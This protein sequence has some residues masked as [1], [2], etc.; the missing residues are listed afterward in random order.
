M[1]HTT[2]E[3]PQHTKSGYSAF[4]FSTNTGAEF[5]LKP[6]LSAGRDIINHLQQSLEYTQNGE[7]AFSLPASLPVSVP[8]TLPVQK[9]AGF[10]LNPDLSAGWDVLD[11]L[12]P[13]VAQ[14]RDT[15][16]ARGRGKQK[17]RL[18]L[19]KQAKP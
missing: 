1:Q 11:N 4:S 14:K 8:A 3:S 7:S 18:K 16:S 17:K 6:D 2:T 5:Y 12:Q 19:S 13:S 9:D 10:Y 15:C